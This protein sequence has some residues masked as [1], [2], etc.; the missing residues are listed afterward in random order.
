MRGARKNSKVFDYYDELQ[1]CSSVVYLTVKTHHILDITIMIISSSVC[2][3]NSRDGI[4]MS[5]STH[6]NE[7][8]KSSKITRVTE[9]PTLMQL[10]K[11]LLSVS[12]QLTIVKDSLFSTSLLLLLVMMMTQSHHSWLEKTDKSLTLHQHHCIM[13]CFFTN[14][15]LGFTKKMHFHSCCWY[16]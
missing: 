5:T 11:H 1:L 4:V 8:N 12:R 15:D 2:T 3:Q 16:W 10:L 14:T 13:P 9:D 6:K 7:A